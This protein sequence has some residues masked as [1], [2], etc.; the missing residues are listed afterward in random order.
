MLPLLVVYFHRFSL[1][2]LVLN[3]GVSAVMAVLIFTG[4]AGLITALLSTTAATPLF[5]LTNFLQLLMV[6]GVDPF[7]RLGI[8]SVRL[9][10]YSGPAAM[11]YGVFFIPLILLASILPRWNPLAGPKHTGRLRSRSF[12]TIT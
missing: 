3:I 5:A 9:P 8:A 7:A 10:E 1:S 12:V 11:I 4:L 6:H 2:G